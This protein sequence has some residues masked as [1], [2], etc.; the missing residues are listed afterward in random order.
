[1]VSGATRRWPW[2]G[3]PR[4]V[5][6]ILDTFGGLADAEFVGWFDPTFPVTGD[7]PQ[8]KVSIYRK[9]D[10][11]MIALASWSPKTENVRLALDWEALGLDPVKTTLWAPASG[12]IQREEVFPLIPTSRSSQTKAGC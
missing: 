1:M 6:K 12:N 8:I 4:P 3:D 11:V 10:K 2:S 7:N 9:P 5:W